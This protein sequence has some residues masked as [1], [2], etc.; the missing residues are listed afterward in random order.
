MAYVRSGRPARS[1]RG[2]CVPGSAACAA[3]ARRFPLTLMPL[4][5]VSAEEAGD[6]SASSAAPARLFPGAPVPQPAG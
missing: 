2:C 1:G 6:S 5:F 3:V 4:R